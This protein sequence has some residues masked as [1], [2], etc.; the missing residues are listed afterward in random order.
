[1]L[2][3]PPFIPTAIDE[4]ELGKRFSSDV[5]AQAPEPPYIPLTQVPFIGF[6]KTL[7]GTCSTGL[8]PFN[9]SL[10]VSNSFYES[11][12]SS[13][14]AKEDEETVAKLRQELNEKNELLEERF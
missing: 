13:A 1:M 11:P 6:T 12:N 8:T 9:R 3:L 4:Q 7:H 2:E 10:N 14:L 5:S